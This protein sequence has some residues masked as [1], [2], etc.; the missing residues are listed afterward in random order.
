MTHLMLQHNSQQ[1]SPGIAAASIFSR[2][3]QNELFG[4]C[5]NLSGRFA[6]RWALLGLGNR[7]TQRGCGPETRE[8]S[9]PVKASLGSRTILAGD[10][11]RAWEGAASSAGNVHLYQVLLTTS[12]SSH[13]WLV[14]AR[15]L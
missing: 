1:K 11:A 12:A 6:R 2:N 10:G 13:Q 7:V 3:W 14:C 15:S 5:R 9:G 8:L 4:L